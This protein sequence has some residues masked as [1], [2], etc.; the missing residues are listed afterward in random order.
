MLFSKC[1][2]I[3]NFKCDKLFVKLVLRCS[4]VLIWFSCGRVFIYMGSLHNHYTFDLI[5]I[6]M[7]EIPLALES[8]WCQKKK[9]QLVMKIFAV[10]ARQKV[11]SNPLISE[12]VL[13]YRF[14][15]SLDDL[16][17]KDFFSGGEGELVFISFNAWPSSIFISICDDSLINNID[18]FL[19]ACLCHVTYISYSSSPVYEFFCFFI[20]QH[21]GFCSICC[22]RTKVVHVMERIGQ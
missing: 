6:W 1:L 2:K 18:N 20:F 22:F 7:W 16:N 5:P 19:I 9:Q 17:F 21:S 4:T 3:Q 12:E 15:N 11:S 13:Y 14:K 10:I 8:I